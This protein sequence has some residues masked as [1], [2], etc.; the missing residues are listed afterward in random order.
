MPESCALG[1]FPVSILRAMAI[2][3]VLILFG[4]LP[5]VAAALTVPSALCADD[6]RVNERPPVDRTALERHWGLD[7]AS[8]RARLGDAAHR[9][10]AGDGPAG[11]LAPVLDDLAACALLDRRS[12]APVPHAEL[13]RAGRGLQSAL[14]RGDRVAA[15]LAAEKIVSRIHLRR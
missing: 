2:R 10:T 3:T 7:C 4:S 15:G 14:T 6:D 5:F 9:V 8:A 1:S 11:D 13:L 12:P